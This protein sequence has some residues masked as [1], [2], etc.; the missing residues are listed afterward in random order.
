[1][2]GQ[3]GNYCDQNRY[4]SNS[5]DIIEVIVGLEKDST[6]ATLGEMREATV[7]QDQV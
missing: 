4:R 5:G 7:D 1:M 3:G 6:Q 2:R